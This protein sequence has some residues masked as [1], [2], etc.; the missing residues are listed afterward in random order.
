MTNADSQGGSATAADYSAATNRSRN[1]PNS[2]MHFTL[3]GLVG[4]HDALAISAKLFPPTAVE[5]NTAIEQDAAAQSEATVGE[6]ARCFDLEL[7]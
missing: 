4:E 6:P 1:L 7:T 2:V 5:Y 3:H